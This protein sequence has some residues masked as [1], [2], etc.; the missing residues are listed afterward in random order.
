MIGAAK[1]IVANV[2]PPVAVRGLRS[3]LRRKS[4]EP[5]PASFLEFDGD[6]ASFS[7]AAEHSIGYDSEIIA[8]GAARRFAAMLAENAT[9]EID[10]RFQIVHS[11]LSHVVDRI[12]KNRISVLDIG[13][14]AGTYYFVLNR[15]MSSMNLDWTILETETMVRECSR[16]SQSIQFVTEMPEANYDVALISGALQYIDHPYEL[17]VGTAAHARWI[18]LTRLPV[19]KS[20][21]D[22]IV[23]QHVPPQIYEGS[24]PMV[25]FDEQT[26]LK[27]LSE[28]GEI[29]LSWDVAADSR[30]WLSY[31]FQSRG[32]L[33]RVQ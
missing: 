11:A 23:V 13:G 28:I 33:V 9:A 8:K 29:V 24:M 20:G 10:S 32:Y 6:Y 7:E 16:I 21:R 31:G 2:L 27:H 17:L 26:L 30:S 25:C 14:G 15:L 3:I 22:R 5:S 4:N 1:Q 12:G 18:I 19:Q